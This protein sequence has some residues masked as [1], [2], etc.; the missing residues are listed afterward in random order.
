VLVSVRDTGEGIRP[1]LL[2]AV[3]EPFRQADASTTRQ[4]GGLGLGLAIVKQ[5]VNAHGGTVHAESL[6]EGHGTKVVVELPARDGALSEP[7][8]VTHPSQPEVTL[9]AA[10]SVRLDGLRVLVVDDEEDSRNMLRELLTA[11]GAQVRT[12]GS[13]SEALDLCRPFHPDILVSDIGMPLL[14]G[15][16]L[17][18]RLRA[19]PPSEGGE[20]PAIAL[21]AYARLEDAQRAF[22]AGYQAHVAKPVDPSHLVNAIA[23]LATVSPRPSRRRSK[24]VTPSRRG[25][26]D[27]GGR[28]GSR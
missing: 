26:H 11:Q 12:A 27:L 24:G 22:T 10:P 8:P 1:D 3:F 2:H 19:L 21:T 23:D 15:Y 25:R 16:G 4:H 28:P 17:I 6:G 14:D 5:L 13:A 7:R 9:G 18:R 20:T